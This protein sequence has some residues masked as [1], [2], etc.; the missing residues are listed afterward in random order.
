MSAYMHYTGTPTDEAARVG[1]ELQHDL[2]R[3]P[4][5]DR[6]C[7][8]VNVRELGEPNLAHPAHAAAV[9]DLVIAAEL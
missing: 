3:I 6:R 5:A 7:H 8:L 9:A 4:R 1:R 2:P